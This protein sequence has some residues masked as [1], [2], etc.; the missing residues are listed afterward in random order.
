MYVYDFGRGGWE[1]V[2]CR[3]GG[4]C[5]SGR[6]SAVAQVYG[7]SLYL[8]GGY[9]GENVLNDFYKFRLKPVSIPPSAFIN[10]MQTLLNDPDMSDIT[11]SIEG[12]EIH[13]NRAI[14]AVRSEYFKIML[15]Q[16]G[17]KESLQ[18]Q[19][20][21]QHTDNDDNATTTSPP[22]PQDCRRHPIEMKDITFSVFQK[23]LEFLY[24]DVVKDFS[25]L[26]DGIHLL[27]ASERFMLERLKALCEE[28]L[29]EFVCVE[30]VIDIVMESHRYNAFGLKDICLEYIL[31]H[32][33]NPVIIDG[34]ADLKSE[35]ELLV[36]IIKRKA[37][38]QTVT[39]PQSPSGPFGSGSG[40]GGTKR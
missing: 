22:P 25:S 23:V 13:A 8:F 30:S 17:M 3:K 28:L 11:F 29:I 2:D 9:N 36:E 33:T 5:P 20:E 16:S 24:T 32:L 7:N 12:K 6:S 35:P 37:G 14:L 15:Y 21:Q 27:V 39:Q 10:N 19:Q 1:E 34:L 38:T 18:A 31:K 26:K 4:W 40:W